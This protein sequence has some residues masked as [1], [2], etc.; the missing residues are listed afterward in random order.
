K[1]A[2]GFASRPSTTSPN[3][4]SSPTASIRSTAGGASR[5]QRPLGPG[6]W[7]GSGT[8][9]FSGIG[10]LARRRAGDGD[11]VAEVEVEVVR[12]LAARGAVGPDPH[13]RQQRPRPLP[14][15]HDLRLGVDEVGADAVD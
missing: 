11:G 13:A 10:F 3:S 9:Y 5:L 6:A 1:T 4:A 2:S 15:P 12:G 8:S 7:R 14:E